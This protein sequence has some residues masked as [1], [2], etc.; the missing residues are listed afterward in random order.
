MLHQYFNDEILR[1]Y[2]TALLE[3]TV[4]QTAYCTYSLILIPTPPAKLIFRFQVIKHII[5]HKRMD[6]IL[7]SNSHPCCRINPLLRPLLQSCCFF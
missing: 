3:I 7:M 5:L 2:I 1:Y 4:L 6:L